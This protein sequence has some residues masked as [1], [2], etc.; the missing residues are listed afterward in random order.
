MTIMTEAEEF[1][2]IV[3]DDDVVF[4][5]ALRHE[6]HGNP[7]LVHR[8][9]HV[10]VFNSQGDEL[11]LQKRSLNKDIQPGKWDTSVGGHVDCG[12]SYLA[13]AVREM[14]E[15][16]GFKGLSLTYLYNSKIRNLVESENVQTFLAMTDCHI[17]YNT[18]EIIEV[19]F[20]TRQEIVESLGTGIFTPN[21][22]EEWHMFNEFVRR[23]Q[24]AAGEGM[25]LCP[26]TSFPDLSRLLDEPLPYPLSPA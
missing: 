12:E 4:G 18:E 17:S 16:L 6:C 13:A 14:D 5:R 9:V 3:N 20:W 26:G 21:F 1:F 10:L 2:D 25:E 22:E 7:S 8:A 11:L 19:R 24:A 23:N 15:E